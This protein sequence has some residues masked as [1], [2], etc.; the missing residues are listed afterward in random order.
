MS[1]NGTD[2][3]AYLDRI[4]ADKS[5]IAKEDMLKRVIDD[6][7]FQRALIY[8]YNPFITFGVTPPRAKA[9]GRQQ[10]TEA[11]KVW[12]ALDALADR[13][14][15][16][17]AAQ[18]CVREW[19]VDVLDQ[20]SSDLLFRILSKDLRCGISVK[21][22]NKVKPGLIPTFDVMLAHKYEVKRI[23]TWPAAVEPKLDGLRVIA[24]AQNGDVRF[25]SRTG[26]P[27]TS[28]DHL[29]LPVLTMLDG[30]RAGV[31]NAETAVE[32]GIPEKLREVYWKLLGD[33]KPR[34][35]LDG[36]VVSGNF[37]ETTGAV[38]RKDELAEDAVFN[39]FDAL[40][41]GLFA[42]ASAD[43][44][45]PYKVRRGFTEH[46]L[47]HALPE[48][49]LKLVPRY[50]VN[51][52]DEIQTYYQT[53]RDR[54]LEGAIVKPLDGFYQKKRSFGWMKMKAEESVDVRV[55]GAFEGT[56]KYEGQLGGLIVDVDGVEVRVGGGFTDEERRRLWEA[57]QRDQAVRHW[58]SP[59]PNPEVLGRLIEVEY[60]EKT[61]D[62]SLRHPRF[63]AWRD[64][65]D[66]GIEEAA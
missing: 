9:A 56:G 2:V 65:K 44:K 48:S 58:P 21:T 8:A 41:Y 50:L 59:G 49:P 66:A 11:S 3:L 6:P 42:G 40:P 52:V 64:D 13:T 53:F 19:M 37:N 35:V 47:R 1:M 55:T 20:P 32:L 22:I 46:V 27:F 23:V 43:I 29:V 34:L 60:H 4:A 16:G 61:P 45:L 10:I 18:V 39:V 28:L 7:V 33:D 36:E 63:V 26:K 51:S 5:R 30:A 12:A 17:N 24:V 62:G 31:Q 25:Y 38:R 54:G 15:T 57:F 14:F